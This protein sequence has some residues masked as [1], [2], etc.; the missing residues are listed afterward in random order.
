MLIS[1]KSK[2]T[3]DACRFCWMCRH[4]CPIGN[5]TGQERNNAR[6]RALS[7]SLVLRESA[8][9]EDAIDNVYECAMCGACTKECV[10]GWDPLQFTRE[11]RREAALTGKTPDYILRLMDNIEASG[12]A[13]GVDCIRED[14][15]AAIG[16]LP[17]QS[18]TLLF[19]GRD[20]LYK[21]PASALS[22]IRLLQSAKLDFTVL[23]HEPGSGTDLDFLLGDVE[24][25]RQAM[26]RCAEALSGFS[27][28]IVYDPADAKVFL[29]TCKE[30]NLPLRPEIRTYTSL[31]A[32][33]VRTGELKPKRGEGSFTFQDPAVLVRDLEEHHPA[34]EI[35]EACGRVKELQ[36]SGKDVMWAGN[37]LMHEYM[38]DVIVQ[39]AAERWRNAVLE[40]VET[41]V[42]ASPGEY[43]AL[44]MAKP[45]GIGLMRLEDVVLEAFR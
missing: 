41:L 3:I 11:V 17:R 39:V 32:E 28:V 8:T 24:E 35:L 22:A 26:L 29:R 9:L 12:N 34:R 23:E 27:R 18:D 43:E 15:A 2:E 44:L 38:P 42:T 20:S 1:P 16:A 45:E 31:I 21:S 14:V 25:T 6:G 5:V 36:L 7:L 10:T 4:V 30:W 37:L 33:L 13:Y 40:G 19:L